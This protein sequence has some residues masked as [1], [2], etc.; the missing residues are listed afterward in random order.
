MHQNL[1]RRTRHEGRL[2]FFASA[3]KQ[4]ALGKPFLRLQTPVG[5]ATL[6]VLKL[7]SLMWVGTEEVICAGMWVLIPIVEHAH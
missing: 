6:L 3:F 2:F 7:D 1:H 4:K 5:G